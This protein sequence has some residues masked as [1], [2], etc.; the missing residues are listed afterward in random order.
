LSHRSVTEEELVE[1]AKKQDINDFI[2]VEMKIIF[3][4]VMPMRL[5]DDFNDDVS[6]LRILHSFYSDESECIV[7]YLFFLRRSDDMTETEYC[8]FR[9]RTLKFVVK[10]DQ[11]FQRADKNVSLRRVV[12][13][14][15]DRQNIMKQLHDEHE[16]RDREETFEVISA[17][18]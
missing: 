12:N 15:T 16:H 7:I 8:A 5:N 14:L 1:Q 11:L 13:D 6:S 10:E 18:Y 2:Q 9:K 4:R 3:A 17:R